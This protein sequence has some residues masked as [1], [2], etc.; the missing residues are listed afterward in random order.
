MT[1]TLPRMHFQILLICYDFGDIFAYSPT[2]LTECNLLECENITDPNA[3]PH[4]S[5]PY[6]LNDTMRSHVD[7]QLDELLTAGVITEADG[8]S[9]ASPIVLVRKKS[10]DWRFCVDMRRLNAICVPL[11]H[12]LPVVDDIIDV[13]TKNKAKVIS[14]CDLKSAYHQL[15]ITEESS[16]KTCFVTP[17]RG[18][19][20]YLRLPQGCSQSPFFMQL[21]LNKLFRHQIETYLLV[22]L[23]DVICVSESPEQ[24][25]NRLR[26]V[27]EK[28][29]K[30]NLKL[31]T[32][33]CNFLKSE[34][35]YLGFI[36]SAK[37][38]KNDPKKTDLYD[39]TLH[40]QKSKN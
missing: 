9:F 16:Y 39:I 37:G 31:S 11:Y 15:K 38:V 1:V 35:Q 26:T 25:L 40:L 14:V 8:S 27:F 33:K 32:N 12:D 20:R 5:R 23:D 4:R 28:F 6:R 36:F 30:A 13:V 34:V 10:G 17:H 19:Y 18:S 24:H 3:K 21:A 29:R 7:R 22:Y 2:D